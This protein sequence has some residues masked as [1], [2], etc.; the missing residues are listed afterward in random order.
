[1]KTID[2]LYLIAD[3]KIRSQAIKNALANPSFKMEWESTDLYFALSMAFTWK[4]TPRRQGYEYWYEIADKA[5]RG[6]IALRSIYA[7][8]S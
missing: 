6:Q 2:W 1:M 7:I 5:K 4:N 3:S 8:A